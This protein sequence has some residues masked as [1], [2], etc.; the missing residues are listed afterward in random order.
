MEEGVFVVEGPTMLRE[1]LAA[2]VAVEGT[3]V[4]QGAPAPLVE[5]AE[6]AAATGVPVHLLAPGTVAGVASLTSPPPLLSVVQAPRHRPD[7]VLVRGPDGRGLVLVLAGVADPGNA[8]TL[9]RTG[10]AAGASGVVALEGTV[11]LTN[12]KAVRAAAGSLFRV[13]VW[14]DAPIEAVG[15]LVA[16]GWD[17]VGTAA[18]GSARHDVHPWGE[19]VALVLGSEAH[20]VPDEVA[21]LVPTWVR[22]PMAGGVESLNVAVAGAVVAFEATRDR[23]SGGDDGPGPT[24]LAGRAG[25]GRVGA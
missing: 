1:A 21:A 14:V 11:D 2:G 3:Y 4:E 9:V 23:R 25:A 15:R 5:A 24:D 6:E 16:E 13:P 20:G 19:A 10:E 22:I 7:D 12:P 17:V 18:D 8:G